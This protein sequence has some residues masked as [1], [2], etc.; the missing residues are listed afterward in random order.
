MGHNRSYCTRGE[1]ALGLIAS[2]IIVGLFIF[3]MW[4]LVFCFIFDF[5]NTVKLIGVLL[6]LIVPWCLLMWKGNWV[7]E[8]IS[9]AVGYGI[10]LVERM[11]APAT[12]KEE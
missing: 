12:G 2:I 8:R 7:L 11:A 4:M 5:I 3:C 1:D 9:C 6:T 10:Y